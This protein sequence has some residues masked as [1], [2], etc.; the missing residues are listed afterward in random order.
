MTELRGVGFFRE[1]DIG[2]PSGPSL[3]GSQSLTP[4]DHEDEIVWYLDASPVLMWSPVVERDA[5]DPDTVI[6]TQIIHTDGVWQWPAGLVHYVRRYHVAL[7]RE[8]V[9]HM[10]SRR[11][12]PPAPQ[13]VDID[14]A[15]LLGVTP[16]DA[17][18][19]T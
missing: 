15:A 10:A 11:W 17:G 12:T 4:L 13:D 3:R 14:V 8:F 16:D 19:P 1:L 18:A 9:A 7:D 2:D 5:L 6:G